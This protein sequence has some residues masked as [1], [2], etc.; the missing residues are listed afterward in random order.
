MSEGMDLGAADGRRGAMV[1]EGF[2]DRVKAR[3]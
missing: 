1:I 2:I 3:T